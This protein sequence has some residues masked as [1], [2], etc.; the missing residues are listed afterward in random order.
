MLILRTQ[1]GQSPSLI[2][3]FDF[4]TDGGKAAWP[5]QEGE[6]GNLYRT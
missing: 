6:L 1:G 3:Q 5:A 2:N 4:K